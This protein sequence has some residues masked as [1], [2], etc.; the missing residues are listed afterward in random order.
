MNRESKLYLLLSLL[1]TQP[2]EFWDRLRNFIEGRYERKKPERDLPQA[3]RMETLTTLLLQ[4]VNWDLEGALRE[5]AMRQIEWHVHR[6][7]SSSKGNR[8]FDPLHSADLTL[9]RFCY[10]VCRTLSPTT[11]IETGVAYGVTTSYVLQALAQNRRGSLWSID[12]PPLCPMADQCV[13]L[14]V[15][16]ELRTVWQ[17]ERGV[18]RRHLPG[19]LDRVRT[20][21]LFI[22]DSLHTRSNMTWEFETVWPHLR[23]GG[24][25]IADDVQGQAAFPDF[26]AKVHP[27]F[28]AVVIE[29]SKD[30]TFGVAVKGP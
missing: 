7:T 11:V 24:V 14:F 16:Q 25:L 20:V 13:G 4:I 29:D 15:P 17:L 5:T 26:V 27:Q 12:L 10:A 21:D 19:L 3:I 2:V 1:R 28:S 30:A 6:Q 9:A 22:H 8:P 18:T 23:P